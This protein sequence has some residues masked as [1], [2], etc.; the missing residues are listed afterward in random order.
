MISAYQDVVNEVRTL[1]GIEEAIAMAIAREREAREFYLHNST[2]MENPKFKELYEYLANEELK[3]LSYLEKYRDTKELP[4][5]G[6]KVNS[7]QSFTPEFNPTLKKGGEF[8]LGDTGILLA[9]MR[10]ERK[11]EYFYSELIKW[12]ID[13]VQRNFF[14]MLTSV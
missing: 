1:K 12:A 14:E 6:T 3:H 11:S 8:V 7:G 2:L 4:V 10:H 5:V 13:D 9:A